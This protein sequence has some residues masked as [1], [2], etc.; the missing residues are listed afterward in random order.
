MKD[1]TINDFLSVPQIKAAWKIYQE[2]PMGFAR[3]CAD[4]VIGPNIK[5]INKRLGQ[6][7]DPLFLAYLC[8]HA[9]N[10]YKEATWTTSTI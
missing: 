9:F 2:S 3:K 7:N 4:E 6:Q 10:E 5:K 1:I 8:E